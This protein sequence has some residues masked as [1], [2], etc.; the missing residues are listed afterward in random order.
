MVN[1]YRQS[2][3]FLQIPLADAPPTWSGS[4]D[5]AAPNLQSSKWH[6]EG[7]ESARSLEGGNDITLVA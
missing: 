5:I 4:A 3:R 1:R 2:G 7:I 6:T